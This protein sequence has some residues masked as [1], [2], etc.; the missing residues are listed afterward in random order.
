VGA[1]TVDRAVFHAH[2]DHADGRRLII[3][4]EV[5]GE[6]LDEEFDELRSAWP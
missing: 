5:D 3:H 1:E 6:I 2:G 4:D